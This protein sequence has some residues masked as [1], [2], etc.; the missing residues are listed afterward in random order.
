[1]SNKIKLLNIFLITGV[2]ASTLFSSAALVAPHHSYAQTAKE[3]A[4]KGAQI[5][6]C[7][8]PA[9]G[10]TVDKVLRFALNTLSIAAGIVAVVMIIVGG[11]KYMTSQGDANQTAAAKNTILYAVVGVIIAVLAQVIVHFVLS[12]VNK[13]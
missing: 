13:T 1:M 8:V 9:G 3:A 2:V 5:E 12:R 11:F 7:N 6:G 10:L 4:C